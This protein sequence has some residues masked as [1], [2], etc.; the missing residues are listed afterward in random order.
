MFFYAILIVRNQS[1]AVALILNLSTF[2][3][4]KIILRGSGDNLSTK[5]PT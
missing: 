5:R 2:A 3:S 1:L 4:Q